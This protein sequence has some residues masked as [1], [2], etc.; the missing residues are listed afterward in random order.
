[1]TDQP[2]DVFELPLRVRYCETDAMAVVHHSNYFNY[3]ELS[4]TELFKARGGNYR[5]MEA[6]GFFLVIVHVECDYKSPARFDDEL[7]IRVWISRQT[8]AKLEHRYQ[9]LC[10]SRLVATGHSVLA[11]V[12]GKGTVQRITD[13]ILYGSARAVEN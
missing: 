7:T 4:R 2:D 8:P 6:R 11:C 3:F 10:G 13:E 9:V 5:E 12:D 1:M